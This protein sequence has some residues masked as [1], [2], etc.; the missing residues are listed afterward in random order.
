MQIPGPAPV[1]VG[2][3]GTAAG[4]AATR[5]AARE[6]MARGHPLR[7]VHVFTGPGAGS[8]DAPD[9]AQARHEASEIVAEAVG[10]ATRTVPGV[11]VEGLVLDGLPVRELLRLSRNAELLVLAD[12]DLASTPRLPVDSV[13]VQVASRSRR[14]VFVARGI[15]PPAGP[16]MTA[17]DGSPTSLL[18]LRVAAAEAERRGTALEVLHVVETEAGRA[19]GQLLLDTAVATLPGSWPVRTSLLIGEPAATL[20]RASRR[21]RMMIVGPRGAGGGTLLGG[22]AQQLLRRCACPTVFVHGT[23]AGVTPVAGTVRSAGALMS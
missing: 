16:L 14:P 23:P 9:W 2:V 6:A 15:R 12:D 4:L 17:V 20:V 11:R 22:V 21:A 5:L 1:V 18:A 8:A 19:A 13:L 3:N 10:T 7:V